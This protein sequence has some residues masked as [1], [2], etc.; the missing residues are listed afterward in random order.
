MSIRATQ[1]RSERGET[2]VELVIAIA[3]LGIAGVAILAGMA[4]NVQASTINRNQAGGGAYVRSA[5]EAIQQQVDAMGKYSSCADAVNPSKA[6]WTAANSVIKSTDVSK[7]YTVKIV[8]VQSWKGSATGWGQ[9]DGN[10]VQR[11]QLEL[12]TPGDSTHGAVETMYVTLRQPCDAA[13]ATPC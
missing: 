1:L 10:G 3:I 13:G 11:L 2:L 6:Y 9:C 5:A 12:T 7:G 8:A 4:F